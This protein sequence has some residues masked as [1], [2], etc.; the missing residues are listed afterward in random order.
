M[1]ERL[2]RE[3]LENLL[4]LAN[5]L[6]GALYRCQNDPGWTM[7]FLSEGILAL[8][9]YTRAAFLD[10]R[11]ITYGDLITSEHRAPV[12]DAVQASL[13][14]RS[15]WEIRYQIQ[16][17]DG[18]IRWVWERGLGIFE[19]GELA[20]LAGYVVDVESQVRAELELARRDAMIS[21]LS[22]PVL[23]IWEG[24]LVVPIIGEF[25]QRRS[26][27]VLVALLER[28]QTSRAG[29]VLLDVTGVPQLSPAG[30]DLLLRVD[31]ATRLLGARC[32]VTGV[33]PHV[34]RTL[35]ELDSRLRSLQTARTLKDGLSLRL[36]AA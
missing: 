34:A 20:Y 7:D 26:E 27:D 6:P 15:A 30:A 17:H 23:E 18:E 4:S 22:M 33:Q 8:T 25:D 29:W 24:T 10:T 11:E 5:S 19:G 12:W 32:V 21:A 31:R 9:G 13:A 14:R 28:L 36:G 35:A 2:R 3:T 16:R 1:P